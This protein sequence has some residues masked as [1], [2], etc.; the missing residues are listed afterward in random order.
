[1]I[2]QSRRILAAAA[3]VRE[4]SGRFLLIK[5]GKAPEAGLWT[6]P[7]GRVEPGE[8][9]R[10]AAAREVREETSLLVEVGDELWSLDLAVPGAV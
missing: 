2:T 4:E 1:M 10:Q 7:G 5:R 6:F 8:T 9:L 3:V